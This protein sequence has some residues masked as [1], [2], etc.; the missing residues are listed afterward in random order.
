MVFMATSVSATPPVSSDDGTDQDDSKSETEYEW[1]AEY[2]TVFAKTIK[3]LK[4]SEKVAKSWNEF[5]EQNTFLKAKL[6]E[7][8]TKVSH[9]ETKN[10]SF[11][12]K[13]IAKAQKCDLLDHDLKTLKAENTD[14]QGRLK[15][16]LSEL[17]TTK[18]S[19]NR[20][21]TGSKKRDDILCDQKADTNKHGIGYPD[22]A[23]TS[24]AKV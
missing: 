11:A 1:K 13:L 9:L 4:M 3:M 6:S 19:L 20:M 12:D 21:N 15:M 10:N 23:S 8:L 24:N 2:H 17:D 7:A 18:A 16:V 5:E 14:L 22:G